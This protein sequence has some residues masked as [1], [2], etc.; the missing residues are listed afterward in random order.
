MDHYHIRWANSKFDWEAFQTEEEARALA[1]LLK[2]PDEKYVIEKLDGDCQSCDRLSKA[3]AT[4]KS[5]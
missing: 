4:L 2:R 1:E 3:K 5:G